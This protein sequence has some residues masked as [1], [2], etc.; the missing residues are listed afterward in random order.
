MLLKGLGESNQIELQEVTLASGV[1][2]FIK[3]NRLNVD[4]EKQGI[5]LVY[6]SELIRKKE[7]LELDKY[8]ADKAPLFYRSVNSV[9]KDIQEGYF[10]SAMNRTLSKLPTSES[11]QESHFGEIVAGIFA[12]EVLGLRR[13][14]SKLTLLTAENSNAYKM[15]L[16]MYDPNS[17]PLTF[18]FGE[19]KCSPKTGVSVGH[20]KSC[21]ADV[22][23]SM[24]KYKEKDREFDLTAAKD[25]IL[26]VPEEEREKVSSALLP[27]SGSKVAYAGFVVID[28]TTF[29]NDEAQVLRTRKNEKNFDVDIVCI[30]SYS[31]VAENV[32]G[33]LSEILVAGS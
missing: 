12:E 21:F 7:S 27:Y 9:I 19:V 33:K 1:L 17:D 3:A 13:L 29:D 28:N 15:D 10:I 18:I 14:Y 23:N 24:N 2:H 22:F 25:N 20:D 31:D 8:I 16:V 11:F 5:R 30:E 32:Y 26:N 6:R 4:G